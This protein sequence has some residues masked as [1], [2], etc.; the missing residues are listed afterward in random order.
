MPPIR[1]AQILNNLNPGGLERVVLNL[2]QRLDPKD[3]ELH[4]ITLDG[5]GKLFGDLGL[6]PERTCVLE[7]PQSRAGVWSSLPTRAWKVSRFLK[8]RK[9]DVLHSHN[10]TPL[11]VGGFSRSLV[12]PRP[13]HAYSE[14][15]QINSATPTFLKAF[16][17]LARG[18][19]V[20]IA[21]SRD[22]QVRM[23][24]DCHV[25]RPVRVI[26]NGIDDS[27]FRGRDPDDTSIRAEL[28]LKPDDVLIMTAVRLVEAKGLPYLIESAKTVLTKAPNAFFALAGQGPMEDELRALVKQA[29]IE[30]RFKMLGYRTDVSKLI[31]GCDV[32]ALP[33]LWE[34]L[35]L[36]L[37]EALAA[38]KA[39]VCTTVGGNAEVIED[40][41]N[42]RL[43]PPKDP[44]RLTQA[45]LDVIANPT[46]RQSTRAINKAKFDRQ[47]RLDAMIAAHADLYR[48]LA[49]KS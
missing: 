17:H 20:M 43:V 19:D 3:F 15:N 23:I 49:R 24:D 9:I 6:P 13:A 26:Y 18:C 38:G 41:V 7:K 34:G 28:G 8:Q 29:G 4:V 21:V 27:A 35:P 2:V 48:E 31:M 46:F 25:P 1:V 37:L 47:F 44:E 36:A 12:R 10:G 42:G 39:I 16:P 32:Y 45:L 14:H 40:H 22:L 11:L 5:P 30:S 33:S